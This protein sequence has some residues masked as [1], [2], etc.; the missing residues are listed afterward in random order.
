M[1]MRKKILGGKSK[2]PSKP[3]RPPLDSQNHNNQDPNKLAQPEA[4]SLNPIKNAESSRSLPKSD[5]KKNLPI[6]QIF[7][8][9]KICQSEFVSSIQSFPNNLPII[10][11]LDEG[12]PDIDKE[13]SIRQSVYPEPQEEFLPDIEP[14]YNNPQILPNHFTL[15]ADLPDIDGALSNHKPE[16]DFLP[17]IRSSHVEPDPYDNLPDISAPPSVTPGLSTIP[18]NSFKTIPYTQP[19]LNNDIQPI[20][21]AI[22]EIDEDLPDISSW[23]TAYQTSN[24]IPQE[25]LNEEDLPDISNY[26]Q[27]STEESQKSNLQQSLL[28][29]IYQSWQKSMIERKKEASPKEKK[30]KTIK[31]QLPISMKCAYCENDRY[32][33]DFFPMHYGAEKE[34]ICKMCW[35][36]SAIAAEGE[37]IEIKNKCSTCEEW[38]HRYFGDQVCPNNCIVCQDCQYSYIF[39]CK[40]RG[41]KEETCVCCDRKLVKKSQPWHIVAA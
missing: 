38:K 26:T 14:K 9:A 8:D 40:I 30:P 31:I 34:I 12:L 15:Q 27:S 2:K 5:N 1:A 16:E 23:S 37:K 18:K 11:S 35:N 24:R 7:S 10:P 39:I 17:D 41:K 25:D 13:I 21:S 22:K 32:E 3:N 33:S 4:N 36:T 29:S 6:K 28:G 20:L 19:Q